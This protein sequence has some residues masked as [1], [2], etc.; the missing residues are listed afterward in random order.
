MRRGAGEPCMAGSCCLALAPAIYLYVPKHCRQVVR[1]RSQVQV[2]QNV[3]L[4]RVQVRVFNVDEP[5]AAGRRGEDGSGARGSARRNGDR[6]G[7]AW[8][9]L[10]A[11]RAART[12]LVSGKGWDRDE[13]LCMVSGLAAFLSEPCC[14]TSCPPPHSHRHW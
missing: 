4:H 12:A 9:G 10:G 13:P 11:P 3:L 1:L 5:T 2:I 14:H 6:A 8:G 7:R